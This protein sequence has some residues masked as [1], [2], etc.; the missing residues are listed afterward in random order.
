MKADAQTVLERQRTLVPQL[1]KLGVRILPGGDYGFPFNPTG[2][3]ARDL[4]LFVRYFDYT[5]AEVLTAA[6]KLG[7]EIMGMASELG[8]IRPGF[9]ADLLLV[10]G[11][12]LKNV[13]VLQNPANLSAIMK[14]GKF[15]KAPH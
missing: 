9:L 3:N 11:N 4:E 2:R 14:D 1:R 6:T 15:H 8:L 7:G 5:P 10:T 12:P 13:A